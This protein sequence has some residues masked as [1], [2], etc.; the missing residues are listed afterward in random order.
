MVLSALW[1]FSCPLLRYSALSAVHECHVLG[2]SRRLL[3]VTF[4]EDLFLFF[5]QVFNYA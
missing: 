4:E 1:L 2:S 5:H 3:N